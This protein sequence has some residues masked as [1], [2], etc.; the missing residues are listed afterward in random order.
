MGV[1]PFPGPLCHT[2]K[3]TFVSGSITSRC[4]G[5]ESTGRKA[6]P[7]GAAKIEPID[8]AMKENSVTLKSSFSTTPGYAL[9][10]LRVGVT[11]SPD[12]KKRILFSGKLEKTHLL[13]TI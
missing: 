6:G 9:K 3:E 11:V 7:E 2:T 4:S 1:P 13:K 10:S 8:D 5:I 12:E